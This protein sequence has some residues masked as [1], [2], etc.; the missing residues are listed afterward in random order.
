M[1]KL[2]FDDKVLSQPFHDADEMNRRLFLEHALKLTSL[3]ATAPILQ[4][5]G[6]ISPAQA[7]TSALGPT[8]FVH[9]FLRR[10]LCQ[11]NSYLCP[12][13]NISNLANLPN[14]TSLSWKN[15]GLMTS[16]RPSSSANA[17]AENVDYSSDPAYGSQQGQQPIYHARTSVGNYQMPILW[18]SSIPVGATGSATTSM[19]NLISNN[20]SMIYGL[21]SAGAHPLAEAMLLDPEPGSYTIG[22]YISASSPKSFFSALANSNGI[23]TFK[24]PSGSGIRVFQGNQSNDGPA[25]DVLRAVLPTVNS[26]GL[27]ENMSTP[28]RRDW[29]NAISG[30]MMG[31]IE[32]IRLSNMAIHPGISELYSLLQIA[33]EAVDQNSYSQ[34]IADFN[35]TLI[36]YQGLV[37][38]AS[39]MALTSIQG[40]TDSNS[41]N[42]TI[43]RP[44][45]LCFGDMDNRTKVKASEVF[46]TQN[47]YISPEL[48]Y[49]FAFA[50]VALRRKLT[51]VLQLGFDWGSTGTRLLQNSNDMI[52]QPVDNHGHG[53]IANLLS[54]S[55][56]I[57]VFNTLLYEFKRNLQGLSSTYGTV[58][59]EAR[60]NDVSPSS[61]PPV[62]N[63]PNPWKDTLILIN[64]EFPRIHRNSGRGSDHA[65]PSANITLISG[66]ISGFN[67]Y[68]KTT[69]GI[70]STTEYQG[71][72]GRGALAMKKTDGNYLSFK[73]IGV[74]LA[75]IYARGPYHPNL[76]TLSARSSI[77]LSVNQSNGNIE[78]NSLPNYELV[79]S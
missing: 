48:A 65:A 73:D 49:T 58:Y 45:L 56:F 36:K 8:R 41:R 31:A 32:S 27:N 43:S 74:S 34:V 19:K 38:R 1:K 26:S 23:K 5:L 51:N 67:L 72:Q 29:F 39:S 57:Y 64:S 70:N 22:G 61:A 68:G 12:T 13:A 54:N 66:S 28:T 3:I 50:E 24:S 40:V 59:P 55:L 10:G 14:S 53:V 62:S 52:W 21:E 76:Q 47:I 33:K 77:V 7:Q 69:Y 9:F 37:S 18:S 35:T 71:A 16:F 63:Q 4:S 42:V 79:N 46:Q 6:G 30:Q 75:A 17:S 2:K 11:F 60:L 78:I 15:P 44:N 25:M 20:C